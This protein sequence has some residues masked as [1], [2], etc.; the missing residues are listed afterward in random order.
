ML[1]EIFEKIFDFFFKCIIDNFLRINV[2]IKAF[3][4]I[5]EFVI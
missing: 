5:I 1:K 4:K 2:I 3:L